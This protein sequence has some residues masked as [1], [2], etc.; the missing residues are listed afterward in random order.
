MFKEL[1][2][3]YIIAEVAESHYGDL[4]RAFEMI[5]ASSKAGASAVK[6][7]HHIPEAEMLR[8]SPSSSN[9]REPLY[10]FLSRTALTIDQHLQ[11]RQHC[12]QKNIDYLCTPFSLVAANELEHVV[13]PVAYKIGSGELTDLPTLLEI[14]K[15]G[16][17]MIVST[18]MSEV[19]EITETYDALKKVV[20]ELALTN[21]TSAYPPQIGDINLGFIPV[22]K[23]IYP[24]AVIG[25]SDHSPSIYTSLGAVALGAMIIEKHVTID[26]QLEGPDQ[27][28]SITFN[29]LAD[30]VQGAHLIHQSLSSEKQLLKSEK[31]IQQWARRSL[32]Y[33]GN[34]PAGHVL[35]AQDIWGKRPG[36]GIPSKEYWNYIGKTLKT[37]VTFNTLASRE[38]FQ[39]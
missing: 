10:D 15:F 32:V 34:F 5:D 21:C 25:H 4:N 23:S 31:E 22:M 27:E 39:E 38:D 30:L 9:M 13:K 2:S 26:P 35:Q 24:E 36:T 6:F 8:N 17:P 1:K 19:S 14:A 11:L 12:D 28:V 29:E 7:Q 37:E 16:K 18:G 20:V 33:T 3:P